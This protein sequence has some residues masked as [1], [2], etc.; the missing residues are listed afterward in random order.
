MYNVDRIYTQYILIENI[1][2][3]VYNILILSILLTLIINVNVY[4]NYILYLYDYNNFN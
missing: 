2:S 3:N 1:Y 4:G